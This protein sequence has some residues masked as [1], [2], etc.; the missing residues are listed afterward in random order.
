MLDFCAEHGIAA[1]IEVV[2]A[3]EVDAAYDRVVAG[4]VF[5]RAVIDTSTLASA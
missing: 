2:D 3:R 1:D 4:E 5:F